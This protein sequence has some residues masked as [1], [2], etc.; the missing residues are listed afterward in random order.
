MCLSRFLVLLILLALCTPAKAQQSTKVRRIG[1]LSIG[2][3]SSP[4]IEPF[5]QGLRELKYIEGKNIIIEY[6]W[7]NGNAERLPH[8]AA[9]LVGLKVDLI[10]AGDSDAI[11]P[12]AQATSSIPIIMTVSGDPVAAGYIASL[13]RPGGNITGLSNLAPDLAGKRLELLKEV[14][15]RVSSVAI[16]GDSSGASYSAQIKELEIASRGLGMQLQQVSLRESRDLEN[17]LLTIIRNRAAGLFVIP[18]SLTNSSRKRIVTFA[19]ENR[20]PGIYPLSGYVEDGGL[21][22][23]GPNIPEMRRRAAIYVDKVL[24]GGKPSEIPVEQ[25]KKFELV[26]NLKTAKRLGLTIP[27]SV[28]YRADKVIK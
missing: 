5:R 10:V 21:M 4:P 28:L 12:A 3:S 24:K 26:I 18:S 25:P 2:S 13:A 14:A 20:L 27:Q 23:Y 17:A 7:A 16:L 11:S 19:A 22:A 6:R 8:L 9:E 1:Y 15:P